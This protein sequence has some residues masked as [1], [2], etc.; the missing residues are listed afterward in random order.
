MKREL[1]Y[2]SIE[3]GLGW[4]QH[5]F[6]DR[7]MYLGGCAAVTACDLSIYLARTKGLTELYPYDPENLS[8]EDYLAFSRMMKGYLGPRLTGIDTL[9]LYSSGLQAYWQDV[10]AGS[11]TLAHAE[12]TLPWMEAGELIRDRIDSGMIVPFLLLRHQSRALK[13][14]HWHWFNLAG[15]EERQGGFY[16]KV[17]TYGSFR[18]LDFR[19]LWDTGHQRKDGFIRVFA[20]GMG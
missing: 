2:F 7:W 12:G 16:V 13:D 15:Y 11:L 10:G 3:G 6:S 1:D 18:W 14:Y 19:E 5:W 4:N 20:P 9:E 8:K 17:V